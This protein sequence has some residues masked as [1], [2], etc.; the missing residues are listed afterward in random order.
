[1]VALSRH[2]TVLVIAHRLTTLRG[3]DHIVVLD[4]GR[5]VEEGDHDALLARDG[6]YA[7]FWR[8]GR[9]AQGWRLTRSVPVEGG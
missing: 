5:A 8:E 7:A 4:R 6:R 9:R 1:M 3:A 2:H